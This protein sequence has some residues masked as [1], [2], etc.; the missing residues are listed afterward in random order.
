MI[1]EIITSY[2]LYNIYLE[3]NYKRNK[4]NY[5]IKNILTNN[6]KNTKKF[7]KYNIDVYIKSR[8][9]Y[10]NKINDYFQLK[11]DN[12]NYY[13]G[14]IKNLKI[15]FSKFSIYNLDFKNIS[16]NF[17]S[18]NI[19]SYK[20]GDVVEI[21]NQPTFTKTRKIIKNNANNILLKLE[22]NRHFNFINDKYR[23]KNKINKLVWRGGF[24]RFNNIRKYLINNFNNDNLLNIKGGFLSIKEQLKYKFIL[25][26][27][28]NDVATNLKWIMSSNSVCVM[29]KTKCESWFMEDKLIENYHYILVKDDFSDLYDKLNYY[30]NNVNKCLDIIEN[31]HNYCNQFKDK[32]QEEYLNYLVFKKYLKYC[33]NDHKINE[34]NN[35]L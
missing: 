14:S 23:F 16:K 25:S 32:K 27:E 24:N 33:K 34:N 3:K 13:I 11:N 20:P 2:L 18:N 4:I 29:P 35:I 17:N 10:Y 6:I 9:N 15:D 7:E 12:V 19:I 21:I 30:L 1:K 8:V 31:A 26:L 5:Y 28:G 22:H